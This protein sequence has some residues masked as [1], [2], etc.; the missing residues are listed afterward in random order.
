MERRSRERARQL[1]SNRNQ[2]NAVSHADVS[3]V[4]F[5]EPRPS[6]RR[7][8]RQLQSG[9]TD[10]CGSSSEVG[11]KEI[12]YRSRQVQNCLSGYQRLLMIVLDF[13]VDNMH[14]LVRVAASYQEICMQK[15]RSGVETRTRPMPTFT[16]SVIAAFF[17]CYHDIGDRPAL[18][19][20]L[21]CPLYPPVSVQHL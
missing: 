13:D 15:L 16:H 5:L 12:P 9:R 1:E 19:P 3:P 4:V 11:I 18:L 17:A 8:R 20:L 10:E 7:Y 21:R 14:W 2:Q 6:R